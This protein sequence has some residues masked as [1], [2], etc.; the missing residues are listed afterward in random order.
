MGDT[1][2]A[3]SAARPGGTVLYQDHRPAERTTYQLRGSPRGAEHV[4]AF[5]TG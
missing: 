4:G 3:S 5:T 2:T 1:R